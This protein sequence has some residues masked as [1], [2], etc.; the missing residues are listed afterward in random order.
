M[1][2]IDIEAF[3]ETK[4]LTRYV[5]DA[6]TIKQL[7]QNQVLNICIL[8]AEAIAAYFEHCIAHNEEKMI[9]GLHYKMDRSAQLLHSHIHVH[10]C[11]IILV[12][13]VQQIHVHVY[14]F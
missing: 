3:V 10:V 7:H 5:N 6:V 11:T 12:N 9:S 8:L 13:S 1:L 2:Y 14:Y 4:F